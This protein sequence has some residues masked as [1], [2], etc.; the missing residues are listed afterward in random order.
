MV[1]SS[2][3]PTIGRLK[4]IATTFEGMVCGCAD[5]GGQRNDVGPS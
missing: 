4:T 1:A 5:E 2:R 3:V